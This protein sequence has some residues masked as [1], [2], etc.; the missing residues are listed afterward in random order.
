MSKN[1]GKSYD[2]SGIINSFFEQDDLKQLAAEI[3]TLL[4]CPLLVLDDTFHIAAHFSLLDFSDTV[5][6]TAVR[7]R[8]ISYE[9]GAVI[10]K[11]ANLSTGKADFI[12]PDESQ[13]K[14]RFAPLINCG[15]KLG[16]LICVDTDGHLQNVPEDIWKKIETVLAKQMFIEAGRQ[17]K[18][19]ETAEEILIHLLDGGFTSAAYFK[20]QVADT[21]LAELNPYAFALIDLTAYNSRTFEKRS[22]KSE[23]KT[24]FANSHPFIYKGDVFLFLH[25]ENEIPAFR[26]LASDF[27]LKVVVSEPINDI[28]DISKSYPFVYDALKTAVENNFSGNIFTIAE[29]RTLLMLNRIAGC[30][31][32]VCEKLKLLAEHD[33][34]KDTEYCET[35]F[36]YLSCGRSLKNTCDALFTHRNTVL[37]RIRRIKEDFEIPIDESDEYIP[38]LVG[39]ALLLLES[40]GPEF[41]LNRT[42]EPNL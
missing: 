9:V 13:Y 21:Y 33:R 29:L 4:D 28:F 7:C 27:E 12:K 26:Q 3:G 15:V 19:F 37:Y 16:Y 20:L 10:S 38:L 1:N 34:K 41:F 35:V 23:L 11:N 6:E 40:K 36:R 17:D 18:P 30:K 5:F 39:S 31:E 8:E 42:A 22:L 24:L 32:L 25:S 14:R 2:V